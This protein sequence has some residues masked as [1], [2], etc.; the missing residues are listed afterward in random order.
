M[1]CK[2]LQAKTNKIVVLQNRELQ[3][4]EE[5]NIAEFR[6]REKKRIHYKMLLESGKI[7]N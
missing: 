6:R 4:L 5:S 3:Q 2:I 7:G 1:Y